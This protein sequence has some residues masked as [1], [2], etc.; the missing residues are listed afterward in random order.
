[1]NIAIAAKDKDIKSRLDK[2]FDDANY[3]I[4]VNTK[5]K[6]EFN[7]LSNPHKKVL[8]GKGILSAQFLINKGIDGVVFQEC[9]DNAMKLFDCAGIKLFFEKN[10][11]INEIIDKISGKIESNIDV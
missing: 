4:I 8:E 6:N 2:K 10:I 9:G 1:M 7:I 3:F 5:N 11:Y